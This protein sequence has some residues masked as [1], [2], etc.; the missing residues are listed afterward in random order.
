MWRKCEKLFPC[1][2]TNC[3]IIGVKSPYN[4]SAIKGGS[5]MAQEKNKNGKEIWGTRRW[6]A[7]HYIYS[8]SDKCSER[9]YYDSK[10][11][12]DPIS[13]HQHPCTKEEC[14]FYYDPESDE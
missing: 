2:K 12:R 7:A 10:T 9:L 3:V 14:F 4:K 1:K 6:T 13:H 11:C 8:T 5:V